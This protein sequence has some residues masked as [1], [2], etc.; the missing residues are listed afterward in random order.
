[1]CTDDEQSLDNRC[2]ARQVDR[3]DLYRSQRGLHAPQRTR[4]PA[5]RRAALDAGATRQEIIETFKGV[6]V[7]G[8]HGVAVT[9]P[10]LIEEAGVAGVEPAPRSP[11][12]IDTPVIDQLKG[13]GLFNSAWEAIYEIDPRWLEEFLA[14]GADVYGGFL[15]AKLVE[16]MSI[17]V[18]ASCTHLYTP[19]IRR[20]I[21]GAFALGAISKRSWRS[22]SCAERSEWTP[23]NLAPPSSP[24]SSRTYRPHRKALNRPLRS[25]LLHPAASHAGILHIS[26][27]PEIP[28]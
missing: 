12:D 10:I 7:L 23:A 20:H 24:R 28:L 16:F 21:Q 6:S 14:M 9:L 15:P 17:A 2:A 19:G 25:E 27:C 18:D 22:S 11:E 8:I 4:C 1:M 5:S 26:Q 13:A 3:A